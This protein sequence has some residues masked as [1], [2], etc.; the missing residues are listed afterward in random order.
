MDRLKAEDIKDECIRDLAAAI[1]IQAATDYKRSLSGKWGTPIG[2]NGKRE[3]YK[4]TPEGKTFLLYGKYGWH[5]AS[6]EAIDPPKVYER[7]F[8]SDWFQ[9]LS[10]LYN[11]EELIEFLRKTKDEKAHREW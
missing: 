2:M 11:S 8:E 10:G 7:F 6:S 3:V 9:E 5:P 1:C 4:I